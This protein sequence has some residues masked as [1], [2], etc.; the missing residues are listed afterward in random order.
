LAT[1][2][3]P[4]MDEAALLTC[5]EWVAH[6][7]ELVQSIFPDW[8]FA[9][10]D[11]VAA[12]GLHGALLIG[13]RHPVAPLRVDWLDALSAFSIDLY[14]DGTRVDRGQ[15]AN[16]LDG[17]LSALR[18]LVALLARDPVNPPLAA[19]EIVTTG[20]LTRAFPVTPGETW[21]TTLDGI[22]LDGIEIRF[23]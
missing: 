9:A 12:Y 10:A 16:V 18:H 14:R 7:F 8:K 13:D 15:A 20:T 4:D 17:P 11:T 23:A 2:P 3:E 22:A 21:R 1:A 19:G 5:V 6:G